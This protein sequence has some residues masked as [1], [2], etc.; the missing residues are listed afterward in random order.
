[1]RVSL[2]NHYVI[3]PFPLASVLIQHA[4]TLRSQVLFVKWNHQSTGTRKG[5]QHLV[6]SVVCFV[7]VFLMR[8][9]QS[10][11]QIWLTGLLESEPSTSAPRAM[12]AFCRPFHHL[13]SLP[14]PNRTVSSPLLSTGEEKRGIHLIHLFLSQRGGRPLGRPVSPA[15]RPPMT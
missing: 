14:P 3:Y 6:N 7:F 12:K 5:L 9:L 2:P 13:P 11:S 10:G 8:K 4:D 15:C 1:M